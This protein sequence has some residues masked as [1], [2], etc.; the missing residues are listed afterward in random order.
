MQLP[1]TVL[2]TKRPSMS[3]KT[4]L[5]ILFCMVAGGAISAGYVAFITLLGVFDKLT[6]Q[7]KSA[8]YAYIIEWLIIGG[9]SLGNLVFL[10]QIPLHLG[11][12]GLFFFNLMGGM[13]T[14]CLAGALAETLKIFPILS[15][16]FSIRH[17]LPY[18]LIAAALGKAVG[19]YIY[20][21]YLCN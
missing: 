10:F 7:T 17:F 8:K 9:V 12:P 5:Y 20:L 21:I 6:E 2:V 15:R 16:R 1:W 13:F 4:I 19:C 3:I 14:G 18:V 11:M